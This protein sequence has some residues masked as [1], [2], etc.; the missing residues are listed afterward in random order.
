MIPITIEDPFV[1][2]FSGP[3]VYGVNEGGSNYIVKCDFREGGALSRH[4][5]NNDSQGIPVGP[6]P[7][8]EVGP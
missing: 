3:M 2:R 8:L 1:G 7:F 5:Q 4:T 6:F